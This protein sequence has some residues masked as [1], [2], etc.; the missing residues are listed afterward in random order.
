MFETASRRIQGIGLFGFKP[1]ASP[2]L[3]GRTQLF[4]VVLQSKCPSRRYVHKTMVTVPN[5]EAPESLSFGY[6][7]PL[8][9]MLKTAPV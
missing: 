2:T 8:G 9:L 3:K 7:G 4:R 1:V 6:F 5:L